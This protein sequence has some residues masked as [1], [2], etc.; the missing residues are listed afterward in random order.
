MKNMLIVD[1]DR[2][3]VLR[4]MNR[5]KGKNIGVS[6]ADTL[7]QAVYL[8]SN[9]KYDLVLANVKIPGGNSLILKNNNH[10]NDTKFYFMSSI[11]SDYNYAS[12]CGEKCIYKYN[13]ENTIEALIG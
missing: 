6:F 2:N 13:I 9:N 4:I 10:I 12:Q 1:D 3:F 7:K 8:V 5:I 11:D